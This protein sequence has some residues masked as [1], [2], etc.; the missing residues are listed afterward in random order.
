MS[1]EISDYFKR[2]MQDHQPSMGAAEAAI[3]GVKEGLKTFAPSLSLS[4]I[5]SDV[6]AELKE[7]WKHGGH[8]LSSAMF[9][10]NA[11]VQYARKD[12]KDEP[13]HGLPQEAQQQEQSRNGREM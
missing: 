13:E 6:T 8:E 10:G 3:E 9:T 11:Y 5:F 1:K 2:S 4:K 7:Q 12:S